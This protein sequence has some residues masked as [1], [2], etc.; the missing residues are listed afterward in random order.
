[1]KMNSITLVKK[2]D[3]T[4]EPYDREKL[5]NSI[6]RRGIP[7]D[8]AKR[9]ASRV[10]EKIYDGIS[11]K[12][13]LKILKDEIAVS[14]VVLKR[15]LRTALGLMKPQPDFEVY[16][17]ELLRGMGY[18]VTSNRVIQGYCVTH[19]IDGTALKDGK[20]Y[21]IETKHHS[22]THIRTPFI[23]TL[24]AKAKLDDIRH[25]YAQGKNDYDFEKVI[26]ICN[27][28]MTTHA[29]QYS[30]CV[31]IDHIGWNSPKG[32]GIEKIIHETNLYP[33][34]ILPSLTKQEH[35]ILSRLGNTTIQDIIQLKTEKLSKT[36]LAQLQQ[37]AQSILS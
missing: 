26:I 1:M 34:T 32:H 33:F 28:R 30:N 25:G 17:Q 14:H 9:I 29:T 6:I 36:R 11:T 37:E 15:D 24:A 20:L 23:A 3:K 8:K 2:W 22:K 10:E 31:G 7:E 35:R 16:I 19:E 4:K 27:T 12:K 18:E 21:Y 13:I 5:V